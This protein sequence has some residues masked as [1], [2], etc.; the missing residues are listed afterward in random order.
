MRLECDLHCT[1][2][3]NVVQGD[4]HGIKFY[5]LIACHNLDNSLA[6]NEYVDKVTPCVQTLFNKIGSSTLLLSLQSLSNRTRMILILLVI[7]VAGFAYFI[8]TGTNKDSASSPI[9]TTQNPFLPPDIKDNGW[10]F[11]RGNHYDG[12]SPEI[13]LAESWTEKGYPIL[14]NRKL[15]QGYSGFVSRGERVYTQYQTVSG[16]FVIC[17]N[18]NSGKTIWEY[19]YGWAYE[20]MSVY[21]GPQATPTL[22][23]EHVYFAAPGGLVGCLKVTDGTLVWSNNPKE[24]YDGKGTD[25]GYACSPTIVD[26]KMILPVGGKGASMV[27]LDIKD[28]SLIWKSGDD[29]SSYTPAFPIEFKGEQQVIGYLENALVCHDVKTGKI[30]W[31]IRYTQGYDEHAAWPIYSEPY[32]WISGPFRSGSKLLM[33]T[34]NDKA[35]TK[36]IRQNNKMSN[37]ICS[38]VLHEGYLYGFD[39]KDVQ[40]KVHRPSRGTF[41]CLDFMT[42][43]QQW[44]SKTIGQSSVIIADGKLILFNDSGELIIA[45][46]TPEKYIEL[47]RHSVLGGEICWTPPTL[48]RGRLFL[49]NKSQAVCVYLGKPELLKL[50]NSESLRTTSDLD[51]KEYLDL[52]MLMGVEPEYAFDVPSNEWYWNWYLLSLQVI[53]APAFV[54]AMF[55]S[56]LVKKERRAYCFQWMFW[57]VAFLLG[58]VGTTMLSRWQNDFVFTLPVCLFVSFQA[59]VSQI[60]SRKENITLKTR[61]ISIAVVSFFCLVC[62]GYYL[63]C[64]RLSLV[65]EWSFL[66]G[67]PAA[68]P[69]SFAAFRLSQKV[70]W[71]RLT[72]FILTIVAFTAFYWSSVV[73]LYL[74]Y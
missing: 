26:D 9:K 66:A 33:I 12:K 74:K 18:A 35:P 72:E 65:F 60:R 4:C 54:V 10:A 6:E 42:G 28:G 67:F 37:D 64:H 73:I 69:F 48:N 56:L 13:N 55:V 11:L 1:V 71:Q 27:A 20:A 8:F 25:F 14:W 68:F 61:C 16:Q 39:L 36:P 29:P 15:G 23:G 21:P 31:R 24:K 45:R 49:R 34:G 41:R 22:H 7:V 43:K 44:E 3:R 70:K 30:V 46:A 63:L 40:A 58:L 47:A 17:M 57:G 32:L 62:V 5:W 2:L 19:R 53:F 50:Q 52:T 51:Q 38:S 59:T